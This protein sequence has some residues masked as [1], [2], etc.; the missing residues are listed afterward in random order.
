MDRSNVL[1]VITIPAL[2]L[3]PLPGCG[4]PSPSPTAPPPPPSVAAPAPTVPA[5]GSPTDS[6]QVYDIVGFE[7][8]DRDVTDS[9]VELWVSLLSS[10]E[11]MQE[12]SVS[13]VRYTPYDPAAG[14]PEVAE[15]VSD[16]LGTRILHLKY[17]SVQPRTQIVLTYEASVRQETDRP[18]A[19]DSG[20]D[21]MTIPTDP[22]VYPAE[23]QQ[24]LTLE[25]DGMLVTS[26][27]ADYALEIAANPRYHNT[28]TYEGLVCAV[29][30]TID[31]YDFRGLSTSEGGERG[32]ITVMPY[33]RTAQEVLEQHTC[34][35]VECSRLACAVLRSQNIPCRTATTFVS[36]EPHDHTWIQVY[37]PDFGWLDVDPQQGEC[38]KD[39]TRT[40][41]HAHIAYEYID[42]TGD[43][44]FAVVVTTN[45][46]TNLRIMQHEE[47]DALLNQADIIWGT[48]P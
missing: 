3:L 1:R 38:P 36:G 7:Q 6:V 19:E 21:N 31:Q 45:P 5:S 34:V 14:I 32:L 29:V 30:D 22:V 27:I 8:A 42:P 28:D 44:G 43:D 9:T 24:Y 17:T 16:E 10:Y 20:W 35:C 2:L 39:L 23:V 26:D 40:G 47:L 33:V 41:E 4:P 25:G 37:V 46:P 15:I 12:A 48:L 18:R 13:N 11:G